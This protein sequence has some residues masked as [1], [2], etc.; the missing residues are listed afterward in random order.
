MTVTV[1]PTPQD[2]GEP[3]SPFCQVCLVRS[4][5]AAIGH[6]VGLCH[7][8]SCGAYSCR[9]CWA[10]AAGVCPACA[11]PFAVE[12][13]PAAVGVVALAVTRRVRIASVLRRMDARRSIAGGALAVVAVVLAVTLAGGIRT[14][15]GVE[16]AIY[17]PSDGAGSIARSSSAPSGSGRATG[18]AGA[19]V[20][21]TTAASAPVRPN[22]TPQG[23]NGGPPPTRTSTPTANP[24]PT[25]QPT[26]VPTPRATPAP[27]PT[28]RPTPRPT[29]GPTPTPTP[30]PKPTPTCLT[31]PSLV[32]KN[33][34]AAR[35]AWT[36]AGFTGSFTPLNGH[37]AKIVKT[38]NQTPGSCLPADTAIVVTTT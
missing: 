7:C 10:D 3:A 32:G 17:V 27:T 8:S 33:V 13:V 26:A 11:F 22:P 5:P 19:S 28:P 16:G 35:A 1:Y 29:P 21:P 6:K 38:Q 15:G 36:A 2:S 9:W 30:T 25:S 34:S 24:G 20:G 14:T 4:D 12:A 31:V 18:T 37:D 23:Q